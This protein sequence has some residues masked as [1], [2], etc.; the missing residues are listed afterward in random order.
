MKTILFPTDFS[1]ASLNAFSYALEFAAAINAEIMTMH[2]YSISPGA[3]MDSEYFLMEHIDIVRRAAVARHKA[4]LLKLDRIVKQKNLGY[5]KMRSLLKEGD[6][7]LEI[8]REAKEGSYDFV[9]TGTK[10]ATGLKEVF[11]GTIAEK[12]INQSTVPVLAIPEKAKFRKIRNILFVA[13]IEKLEMPVFDKIK[14]IAH[15]FEARIEVLH[16][17]SHEEALDKQTVD[18]WNKH[19]EP[20]R[21]GIIYS[22]RE[23]NAIFE[24]VHLNKIDLM[25]LGV[26]HKDLWQRLFLESLSRNLAYHTTIPLLSVPIS[27][28]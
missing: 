26:Y 2:V 8:L 20:V 7:V 12:L 21:F 5:V 27:G 1:K 10:G 28:K 14:D 15:V 18:K 9:I 22:D 3:F 23:E 11:L 19:F 6:T 13:E 16:I 4:E 17:K 24:F 25:A